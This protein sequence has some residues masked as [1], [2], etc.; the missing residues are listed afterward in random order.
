MSSGEVQRIQPVDD[1]MEVTAVS[2]LFREV[3]DHSRSKVFL[4]SMASVKIGIV[5]PMDKILPSALVFLSCSLRHARSMAS[6]PVGPG[7]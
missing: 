5:G 6:R 3:G 2:T 4:W 7:R 1:V